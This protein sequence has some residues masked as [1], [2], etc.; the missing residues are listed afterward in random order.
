MQASARNALS[1]LLYRQLSYPG[2]L[3]AAAA[4]LA[5]AFGVGLRGVSKDP[6][7]D[8]FVPGNHPAALARDI[9]RDTFG[10]EDPIIVGL[11]APDGGSAFTPARLEALRRID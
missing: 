2:R 8:A 6:S 10:L 4:L 3:L 9:A 5:L 1:E 7:V 11:L